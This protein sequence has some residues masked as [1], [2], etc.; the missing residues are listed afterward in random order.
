MWTSDDYCLLFFFLESITVILDVL[1]VEVFYSVFVV[2]DSGCLYFDS[3]RNCGV[4][5]D[6]YIVVC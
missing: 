1:F 3:I 4:A 5:D 6:I 2:G